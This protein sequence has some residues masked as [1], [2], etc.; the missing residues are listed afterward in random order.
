MTMGW[1]ACSHDLKTRNVVANPH[2]HHLLLT[3]AASD[4]GCGVSLEFSANVYYNLTYSHTQ[5]KSSHAF[6]C[7]LPPTPDCSYIIIHDPKVSESQFED[8]WDGFRR[9][10]CA[11][12]PLPMSLEVL[13]KRLV[14]FPNY[15][16]PPTIMKHLISI[17][18][19]ANPT[20]VRSCFPLIFGARMNMLWAFPCSLNRYVVLLLPSQL[21]RIE[22][23]MV[24]TFWAHRYIS[25]KHVSLWY[26]FLEPQLTA[27]YK[28]SWGG[29]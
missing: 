7:W 29:G 10:T 25:F 23:I 16:T 3:K 12:S 6:Q 19:L 18:R 26:M 22:F 21:C 20:Q 11:S 1:Q 14:T 27:P 4:G 24:V 5:S 2:H 13:F 15:P 17:I 8:V 9:W 28:S